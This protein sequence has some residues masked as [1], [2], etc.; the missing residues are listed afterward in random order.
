MIFL[1][2]DDAD[3]STLQAIKY[4]EIKK[5]KNHRLASVTQW[6]SVYL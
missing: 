2:W 3:E 1:K 4:L 5:K 6:L